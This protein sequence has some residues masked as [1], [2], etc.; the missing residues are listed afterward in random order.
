M[1]DV[2]RDLEGK[3]AIITGA[4]TGIGAATAKALTEAGA[5]VAVNYSSSRDEADRVVAQI[6][7]D[8]GQAIAVGA[9][10]SKEDEVHRLFE[11]THKEIGPIDIVVSNAG[12]QKDAE[13]ADMSLDDWNAV[14]AVNLTGAFLVAREAVR[15]FMARP[16][17][18]RRSRGCLIFNSSVHERV[19]WA[20]HVN[21]AASK[22]GLALLMR[23]LAQEVAAH[24][25]RV[26]AVAPGAVRTPIN[27]GDLGENVQDIIPYGRI[28]AVEDIARAI[29]WLASDDADYVIGH[30]LFVDGGMTLY[31]GFKENG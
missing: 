12:I 9:D 23:S 7:G 24:K 10:I 1:T 13:F 16:L 19:P 22:G 17:D 15:A 6:V 20:G 18:E 25:I 2:R 26:N 5:L 28:G 21:Y 30:S 14:I 8:G 4:S 3:V 27:E 29:V 31:P 11:T